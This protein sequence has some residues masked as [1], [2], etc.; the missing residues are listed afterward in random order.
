M[1]LTRGLTE[2]WFEMGYLAG[3]LILVVVF[4]YRALWIETCRR[5]GKTIKQLEK[6]RWI[7][8][9]ERKPQSPTTYECYQDNQRGLPRM[10]YAATWSK[11]EGFWLENGQQ[12]Y[13]T[14]WRVVIFPYQQEKG[15]VCE[16]CG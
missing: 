4:I 9:S 5:W 1:K 15:E 14:H 12:V 16:I 8:V 10:Y 3:A 2:R 11:S 7:K 6:Y 13:P